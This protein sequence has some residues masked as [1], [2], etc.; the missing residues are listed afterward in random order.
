VDSAAF[1]PDGTRV[2]TA[3]EDKTAPVWE[4]LFDGGTLVQWSAIAEQGSYML[5]NGVLSLRLRGSSPGH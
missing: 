3:G 4:I 5:S 1:S 2:V